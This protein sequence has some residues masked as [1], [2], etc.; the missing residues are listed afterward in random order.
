MTISAE[1]QRT[2]TEI[3]EKSHRDG[4]A[5][6]YEHEVYGVLEAVGIQCPRRVFIRNI[7]EITDDMLRQFNKEL[8]VKVVSPDI[9]HKKKLGGVR[10]IAN[11]DP[12]FVQYVVKRMRDEIMEKSPGDNPPHIAGFLLVE[13]V[14]FSESLGYELLLGAKEDPAFGPVLT[15]SKG[16]DDAEFFAEY[17]DPANHFLPHLSY[18]GAMELV[19]SLSIRHKYEDIGHPEYLSYLAGAASS[20]SALLSAFSPLAPESLYHIETMDV[21]PIVIARDGRFL[22]VDGYASFHRAKPEA[23]QPCAPALENMD[24]FFHPKGIAVLGVSTD[25]HKHSMAREIARLL[26]DL[27]RDDLYCIN[28]KG[29]STD[30]NG[31]EYKLYTHM[32]EFPPVDLAVY[33]A[34]ARHIPAFFKS[35]REH[36]PKAVV[37]I[38]GIPSDVD[39]DEFVQEIR[40]AIP[41]GVRVVG[42]NCVG[43]LYG[44]DGDKGVNTLFIEEERLRVRVSHLSNTVLLTQSGGVAITL[45]DKLQNSPI[46]KSIVSFGNKLDVNIADLTAYFDKDDAI[47]VISLYVEGFDR[48]E[49]RAF[50]ELAQKTDKPVIV[51]KGGKT[52]QGAIA[53]ASHTA[54]IAGEYDILRAAC[55]Q[56]GALLLDDIKL[57]YDTVKAFSL[58]SQKVIRGRDMGAV[59][60]AGFEAT[61]LSDELGSLSPA[62]LT[63]ETRKKLKALNTHG[64]VD[65]RNA[66]LDVTPMTND[67]M[68][69]RF[70]EAL[71][72]DPGVDC[73]VVAVV[74]HVDNIKSTPDTCH[75]PDSL[76]HIVADIFAR[77]DKPMVVSVNAGEYYREFVAIMEEAGI[78]VYGNI[79]SAARSLEAYVN[80]HMAKRKG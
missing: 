57:F 44:P 35:I 10:H 7:D 3:L 76:A 32:D 37:L 53:A 23:V 33:A 48:L 16:G 52:A 78:P 49:G 4:R 71:L 69:G 60:N 51:Y 31:T 61:I 2:I 72:K 80:W 63:P 24:A 12:L 11:H 77:C 29:G 64:L 19:G 38:P 26:H 40:N 70:I 68:Y 6:L 54:A 41:P 58:L 47:D 15:L 30:I 20:M 1:A 17:Y 27:G 14:P 25:P 42:P 9:I 28:P 5:M 65:T 62:A 73:L 50:Y 43:I 67:V 79:R 21:N 55:R 66:I 45:I 18:E 36:V 46:F 13:F 59:L 8:M 74:P 22:A 39:Y 34:P 56:A 75:D